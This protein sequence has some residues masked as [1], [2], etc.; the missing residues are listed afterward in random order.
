M[1][2][3]R[4]GVTGTLP[5]RM[6]SYTNRMMLKKRVVTKTWNDL[7]PP[8]T[9]YNHLKKFNNHLQ[10]PKTIYNH[11]K[12]IY[13]HSQTILNHL[14]QGI[15][16]WNKVRRQHVTNMK[17]EKRTKPSW[18]LVSSTIGLSHEMKCEIMLSLLKDLKN[19]TKWTI[20]SQKIIK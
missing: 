12:N 4:W 2:E 16:V 7:K 10:L 14:K 19:F 8:K 6:R 13:N 20:K 3:S 15:N 17:Y 5:E 18:P 1:T 11:L 9:T